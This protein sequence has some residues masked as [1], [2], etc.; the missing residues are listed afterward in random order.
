MEGFTYV[1]IF[2]TKGIEYLLVIGFLIVLIGFFKL[3]NTPAKGY[4]ER[5]ATGDRYF[6]A[7]NVGNIMTDSGKSV[8]KERKEG[9]KRKKKKQGKK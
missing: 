8:D 2:A 9:K 6:V 1:D 3:L 5:E 4:R 7:P